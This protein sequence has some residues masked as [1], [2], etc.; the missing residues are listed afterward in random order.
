MT[1]ATRL[2]SSTQPREKR[3]GGSFTEEQEGRQPREKRPRL[4]QTPDSSATPVHPV[5][6]ER[7]SRMQRTPT[8]LHN[9]QTAL[10]NSMSSECADAA[11][12]GSRQA[13]NLVAGNLRDGT[14]STADASNQETEQP[15]EQ[16]QSASTSLQEAAHSRAVVDGK[17]SS[18]KREGHAGSGVRQA[19]AGSKVTVFSNPLLHRS[20][21]GGGAKER[22]KST[23]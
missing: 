3:R 12:P 10:N 14:A 20:L 11:A 23:E 1:N 17:G 8:I 7:R 19:S 16:K 18:N 22:K 9:K 13:G 5:T 21:L 15:A 2:R 6:S 4:E